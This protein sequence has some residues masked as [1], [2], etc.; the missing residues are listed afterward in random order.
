MSTYQRLTKHP[1]TGEWEKATWHDNLFGGH[2]Y[3]VVFPSDEKVSELETG[4]KWA[5]EARA[6]AFDPEKITLETK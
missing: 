6:I 1:K 2:H 4:E 5:I 3:G